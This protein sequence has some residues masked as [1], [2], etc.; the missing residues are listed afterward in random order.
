[1]L[2]AVSPKSTDAFQLYSQAWG[3]PGDPHSIK[4]FPGSSAGKESAGDAGDPG[5]TS[6]SGR[7]PGEGNGNPLQY[8]GLEN[9]MD[10][11]A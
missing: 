7:S 5:W 1:M 6:G 10:R 2:S 9:P 4:F 8:S 3:I 11:G